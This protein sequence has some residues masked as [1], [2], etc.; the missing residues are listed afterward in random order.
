MQ[1]N[2]RYLHAPRIF[3]LHHLDVF[4]CWKEKAA[5]NKKVAATRNNNKQ[6]KY[7]RGQ[8]PTFTRQ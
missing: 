4:L 7:W 5:K 1:L 2:K 6:V 3:E 8:R